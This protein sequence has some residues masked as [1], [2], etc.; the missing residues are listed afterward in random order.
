MGD[1]VPFKIK[2]GG[3]SSSINC[4]ML[5]ATNCTVWSIRIK[6]LLKLHKVWEVI[7][8]ESDDGEKNNMATSLLF[9]SIPENFILQVGEL[10]TAKKVWDAIKSR[11][12]GADRVREA[13]LQTLMAE[14]NRLKMKDND[15]IDGEVI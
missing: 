3:G 11:H 9:Q 7:E 1:L 5:S 15:T 2:E 10:D 8:N 4:P 13:R 12:M 14:F 6:V